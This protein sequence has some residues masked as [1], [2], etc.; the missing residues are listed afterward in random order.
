MASADQ[1]LHGSR[2][3]PRLLWAGNAGDVAR[4]GCGS[5]FYWFDV[6]G[7]AAMGAKV[8]LGTGA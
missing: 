8:Y 2:F 7:G 5:A 4:A 6:V 1:S 3:A